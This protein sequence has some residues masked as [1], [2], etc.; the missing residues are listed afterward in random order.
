[1]P[2]EIR[3]GMIGAG[4]VGRRHM[5]WY[6]EI[7][8]ANIVAVCDALPKNLAA[9][10]ADFDI[11]DGYAD[12]AD[13]LARDDVDAVDVCVHN[14]KHAPITIAAL[15]AGKHVYCEKP[16]AGTYRDAEDMLNAAGEHGRMLSIQ[17]GSLFSME[18]RVARRLMDDG[19]LGKA[20]YARSLG[21]RRRGR[22]FVDGYATAN[23]V[24]A[25]ICAGGA[26]Y[27]MGIYHIANI[28]YLLDNPDV[29]TVTGAAHQELDMYDDR[30]AFSNYSVEETGL[31]WVRLAGGISFD[32]EETWAGHQAGDESSKILGSKGG[33]RLDPLTFF[34]ELSDV[35]GST[36]FDLDAAEARW[37]ACFPDS[38][39]HASPQRHWIGALQGRVDLLPTAEIALNTMLISE[40]IYMSSRLAR[41]VTADE[42]R[43]ES[44]ST[45]MDPHTPEKVWEE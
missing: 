42:V 34:S 36:T 28:L 44:T 45:A 16:M 33:I 15:A 25:S 2:D 12:L 22:P 43:A 31:G 35:S 37:K 9:A 10:K 39:C 5:T 38:P 11:P 13:L 1:M 17:L 30:R 4:Q 14:N 32:I 20:Y 3:I 19:H 8:G 18:T 26:L 40:G 7:D 24:D 23:F 29:L 21:Y 41:E 27:D 6:R